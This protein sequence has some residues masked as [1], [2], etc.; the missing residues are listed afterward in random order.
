MK[1]PAGRRKP[2][3]VPV[4]PDRE[5]FLDHA[6]AAT[7]DE[8]FERLGEALERRGVVEHRPAFVRLLAEREALGTSALGQGVAFPHVRA[9]VAGATA[10]AFARLERPVE[11][12]APD[13]RA[14][15]VVLMLVAPLDL[16]GAFY[17]PLLAVL[18]ELLRDA[19]GRGKLRAVEHFADL[20]RL[21]RDTVWPRLLEVL[22]Q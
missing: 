13:G 12:D 1:K 21:L 22:S 11:F 20:E 18:A 9:F 17:Q 3:V 19:E 4:Y 14:V 16:R 8:L 5:L 7:R 6:T 15:D 2:V 10:L